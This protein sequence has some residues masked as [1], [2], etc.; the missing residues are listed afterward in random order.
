MPCAQGV[1]IV[2]ENFRERALRIAPILADELAKIASSETLGAFV[3]PP[4]CLRKEMHIIK[5]T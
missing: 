1:P 5:Y 2:E 4:R 3:E